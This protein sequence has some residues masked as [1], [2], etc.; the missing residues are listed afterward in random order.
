MGETRPKAFPYQQVVATNLSKR[1]A[2]TARS[3][4][5]IGRTTAAG[6]SPGV[7][8]SLSCR[9]REGVAMSEE[10]EAAENPRLRHAQ[11]LA[12]QARVDLDEL[13]ASN[14]STPPVGEQELPDDEDEPGSA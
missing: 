14:A 12:D 10:A 3:D 5:T 4:Q 8:I 2:G 1:R 9:Q 6:L 11:Q 7:A 13:V